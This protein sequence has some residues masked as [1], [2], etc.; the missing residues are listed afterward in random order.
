MFLSGLFLCIGMAVAQVQVKGTIISADD[1][2]PLPG[3]S[4]K[5]LGT[6]TGTV[7]D[8]NGD[9]VISVPDSETRLEI[10]HM[11]MIT[12]VVKARNGMRI[13]LD[14]DNRMLDEVMVVAFGQQTKESFTGSATVINADDLKKKTTANVANAL[15]GEVP[16]LQITGQSGAPGAGSGNIYIRGISSLYSDVSPLIIVDGAPYYASLTNINADDIES[17]TVL[18]DA[19]SAALYGAAGAAGVILVTT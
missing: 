11:G 8:M 6:K 13:A 5:V 16:G 14:T 2:E 17:V 7:T 19:A 1:G 10:S 3:A 12:R 9:F 4:V 18:K 15:I